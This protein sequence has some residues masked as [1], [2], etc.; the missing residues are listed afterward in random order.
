MYNTTRKTL[1]VA[2]ISAVT[3]TAAAFPASARSSTYCR[4][5][6]QGER[7]HD[8]FNPVM[9]LPL[10]IV[11]AGA[12]AV[13]GAAVGGLSIAT[14]A[15][16]GAGSGAGFGVLHHTAHRHGKGFK[17]SQDYQDCRAE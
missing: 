1:A 16:V 3:L 7:H 17:H 15:A 12:G 5:Q 13:V 2:L 11:G 6:M 8:G 10:A 9:L 4:D 14:G